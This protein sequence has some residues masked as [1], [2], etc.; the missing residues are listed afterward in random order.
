V[1]WPTLLAL[2][3]S[4]AMDATAVAAARGLA[5]PQVSLSLAAWVGLWFGGAQGVMP[6]LGGL[7]G[8]HLGP[9]LAYQHVISAAVLAGIGVKMIWD[10]RQGEQ[11][12]PPNAALFAVRTM[13]VLAIATSVDAFAVGIMLPWLGANLLVSALVIGVVTALLSALGLLL[14]R[15]LGALLGSRLDALGGVMLLLLAARTLWN[16]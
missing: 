4:L 1:E 2:A 10:A 13:L 12:L 3:V 8:E 11:T 14:G 15:R 9:H 16:G 6:L 7:L 5:A